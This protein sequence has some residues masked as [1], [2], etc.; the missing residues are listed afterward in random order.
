MLDCTTS[1]YEQLYARWLVKPGEL[2]DWAEL[3]PGQRVLDLCGGTGIVTQEALNRDAKSVVLFDL[4]PRWTL[5]QESIPDPRVC[6]IRGDVNAGGLLSRAV[7]MEG[8]FD[9]IVCRQ[10]LGYLDLHHLADAIPRLLS[11]RGRFVFN[12]FVKP[13]WRVN[14]Y[15]FGRRPFLEMSGFFGRAVFHVQAGVSGADFSMFRW[16]QPREI[17]RGL[18]GAT[19]RLALQQLEWRPSRE[20]PKTL[21][22]CWVRPE[23]WKWNSC[24]KTT[25]E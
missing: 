18:R 14:P 10:S 11:L 13:V 6:E 2:L 19:R 24:T 20:N 4:N 12:T 15:W 23:S 1:K 25:E 3:R 17:L 22:M 5:K 9:L 7:M 16:Y 8:P 21:W